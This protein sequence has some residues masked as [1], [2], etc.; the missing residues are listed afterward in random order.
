VNFRDYTSELHTFFGS[1]LAFG[2]GRPTQLAIP[3]G[4]VND[5][6][7]RLGRQQQVWFILLVD[8]RGGVQVKL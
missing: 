1:E 3:P 7:I 5:Y 8:E 2:D 6:Q 4:S